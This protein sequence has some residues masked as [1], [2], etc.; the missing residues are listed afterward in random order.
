MA[1]AL[2]GRARLLALAALGAGVLALALGGAGL[3]PGALAERLRSVTSYL[4]PFDAGAVTVTRA[5]YALV[6]RMAQVQAG[7]RDHPLAH[8][9]SGFGPGNFS[10][11]YPGFAVGAWYVSRGHAHNYYV[12]IA[13]EA[14]LWAWPCTSR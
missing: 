1:L 2:G 5:N 12:H 10:S 7:W 6:E 3:L 9:L 8:P 14:G 13:A 11:A 4:L